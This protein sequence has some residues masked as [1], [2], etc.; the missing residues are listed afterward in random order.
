MLK[1][2]RLLLCL[3]GCAAI[4]F[5]LRIFLMGPN[6]TAKTFGNLSDDLLGMKAYSGGLEHVN[7][8]SEM[9]F[10]SVFWI[11]VASIFYG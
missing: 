4:A 1:T 7:V 2:T 3:L 10:F 9:R 6:Q 8:D 11:A 5:G